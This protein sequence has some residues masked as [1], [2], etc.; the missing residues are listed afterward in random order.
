MKT[1]LP[2]LM[3]FTLS[4]LVIFREKCFQN[5]DPILQ[6]LFY[7]G[8]FLFF[9]LIALVGYNKVNFWVLTTAFIPLIA[10]FHVVKKERLL[11]KFFKH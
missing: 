1:L 6:A 11:K 9:I 4:P 10:F 2:I 8:V 5:I 7:L 3:L